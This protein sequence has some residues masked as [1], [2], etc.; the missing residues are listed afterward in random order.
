MILTT[1]YRK[2]LKI[3]MNSFKDLGKWAQFYKAAVV[4]PTYLLKRGLLPGKNLIITLKFLHRATTL[5]VYLEPSRRSMMEHF[6][7][8]NQRLR[9]VNNFRKNASF[10]MFHRV[11]NTPLSP[12]KLLQEWE[13]MTNLPSLI[14]W[15]YHLYLIIYI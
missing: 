2:V 3:L 4:Q 5:E 10:Q 6:Y 7:K 11:L 9:A 15:R 12:E 13:Y 8:N 14:I 1:N